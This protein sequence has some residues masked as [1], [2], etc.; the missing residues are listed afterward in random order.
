MPKSL[1]SIKRENKGRKVKGQA[2]GGR[3]NAHESAKRGEAHDKG[4]KGTRMQGS[5]STNYEN[6]MG[7]Q[8]ETI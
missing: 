3:N 1:N 6:D 8:Q 2:K 5:N 4:Q 7:A